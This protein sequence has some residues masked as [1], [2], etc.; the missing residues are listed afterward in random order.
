MRASSGVTDDSAAMSS[1]VTVNPTARAMATRCSVWLV[2]PPVAINVTTALTSERSS[3]VAARPAGSALP[4][5]VTA[6]QVAARVSASRSGVPGFSNA[7]PGTISPIASS[8]IW[9]E[10]AVP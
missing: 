8:S 3:T 7:A 1:H 9:L 5:S 10:F 4:A 6:R 2:E